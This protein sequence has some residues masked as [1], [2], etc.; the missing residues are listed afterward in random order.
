MIHVTE[1]LLSKNGS[2]WPYLTTLMRFL[3]HQKTNK[4]TKNGRK[5]FDRPK[6]VSI[7]NPKFF[8]TIVVIFWN[9]VIKVNTYILSN[10]VKTELGPRPRERWVQ[11][12]CLLADIHMEIYIS[13]ISLSNGLNNWIGSHQMWAETSITVHACTNFYKSNYIYSILTEPTNAMQKH[14]EYQL[15]CFRVLFYF[16]FCLPCLTLFFFFFSIWVI[17]LKLQRINC[18]QHNVF[19]D[20]GG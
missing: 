3:H 14:W 18:D 20:E 19:K 7:T 11:R 5:E 15:R 17:S 10:A 6:L 12:E 4:K 9:I 13:L 16:I 2:K 8:G 1:I